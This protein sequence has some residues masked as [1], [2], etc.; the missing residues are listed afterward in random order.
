MH[1]DDSKSNSLCTVQ[2]DGFSPD[3]GTNYGYI[4]W[5]G[6]PSLPEHCKD[7]IDKLKVGL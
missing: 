1:I 6:F 2:E 7:G 5:L 3:Y 4:L